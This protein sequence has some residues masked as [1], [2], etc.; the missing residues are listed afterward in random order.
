MTMQEV[1]DKLKE[2]VPGLKGHIYRATNQWRCCK[3]DIE[4]IQPGTVLTIEDYQMNLVVQFFETTTTS[5]MGP[6]QEQWM[7]FPILI[8]LRKTPESPVTKGGLVF[9]LEDL[10]HDFHQVRPI[11]CSYFQ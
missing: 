7:M 9:L 11:I 2:K 1:V 5:F 10:P 4:N 6:N 8:S 3:A